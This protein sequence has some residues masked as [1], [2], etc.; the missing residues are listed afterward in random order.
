M[1]TLME[2][3]MRRVHFGN[4]RKNRGV[5]LS[6]KVGPATV[7][8]AKRKAESNKVACKALTGAQL[9]TKSAFENNRLVRLSLSPK[10][11]PPEPLPRKTGKMDH[12]LESGNSS[13]ESGRTSG[14]PARGA[15]G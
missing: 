6:A 4:R 13:Q 11:E 5:S 7:I 12:E 8:R 3:S 1:S 2:I 10:A 9:A 15:P 14:P